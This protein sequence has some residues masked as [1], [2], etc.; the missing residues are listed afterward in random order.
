ML[1]SEGSLKSL[2]GADGMVCVSAAAARE[3]Y[4]DMVI[5]R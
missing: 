1:L 3:A 2:A 5:N 4:F